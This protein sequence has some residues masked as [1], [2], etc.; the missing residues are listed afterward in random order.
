MMWNSE[1]AAGFRF[2]M[3]AR[4][5]RICCRYDSPGERSDDAEALVLFLDDAIAAGGETDFFL[6]DRAWGYTEI[7]SFRT[8][9]ALDR[10]SLRN[11]TEPRARLYVSSLR[12]P[13]TRVCG[14]FNPLG[15]TSG[16][17]PTLVSERRLKA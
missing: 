12:S 1:I 7:V 17:F 5:W 16:E 15:G 3:P 6:P 4:I 10:D 8:V 11:Q 13:R 14:W 9:S 2:G